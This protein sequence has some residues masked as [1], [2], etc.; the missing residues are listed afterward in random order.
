MAVFIYPPH[1][2]IN[3][4]NQSKGLVDGTLAL[5]LFRIVLNNYGTFKC[6]NDALDVTILTSQVTFTPLFN[7]TGSK[8]TMYIT[9]CKKD[10]EEIA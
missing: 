1:R 6:I 2:N 4:T 7:W 5:K 3:D 10:I 9:F 8:F